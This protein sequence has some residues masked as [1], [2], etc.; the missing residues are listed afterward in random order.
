LLLIAK[1]SKKV[2]LLASICESFIFNL[3]S[4]YCP[5]C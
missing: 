5:L 1:V 3:Y 2:M 4:D